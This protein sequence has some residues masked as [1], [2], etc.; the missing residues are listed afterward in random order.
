MEREARQLIGL[1]AE[2]PEELDFGSSTSL[3]VRHA[4]GHV[5]MLKMVLTM[6]SKTTGCFWMKSLTASVG[7]ASWPGAFF[8]LRRATAYSVSLR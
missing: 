8:S 7:T 2:E 4:A 6:F 1:K 3:V 5:P